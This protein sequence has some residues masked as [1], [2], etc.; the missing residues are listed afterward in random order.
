MASHARCVGFAILVE[1]LHT[2]GGDVAVQDSVLALQ[3][4]L[5]NEQRLV[6]LIDRIHSA[7]SLDS[8]F[9][10]VQDEMLDF[11]GAERMT[12]YAVDH[13]RKEIY[14]KFLALDAVKEIRV[15]ISARSV[16]GFVALTRQTVNIVQ[17]ELPP[18][19]RSPDIRVLSDSSEMISC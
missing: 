13:D 8:I 9:L 17:P 12:L 19:R 15:P 6:H 2:V 5:A 14:S 18:I 4:R 7:R 16:A 11:F 10:E 3:E 1:Q